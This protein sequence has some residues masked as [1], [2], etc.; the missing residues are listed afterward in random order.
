M[1]SVHISNSR[2]WF[3]FFG[4][5]LVGTSGAMVI[6]G[7]LTIGIFFV[8]IV[9][10]GTVLLLRRPAARTGLPGIIAGPGLPL[11]F[12]AY[13]NRSGPGTVCVTTLTSFGSGQSCSDEWNPWFFLVPGLLFVAIGIFAFSRLKKRSA[14]EVC[15]NCGAFLSPSYNFCPSC[16]ARVSETTLT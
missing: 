2:T 16:S 10:L 7:A 5:M 4:W 1:S 8:P 9:A 15:S 11:L 3:Y 12:I 6:A 14:T 13:L